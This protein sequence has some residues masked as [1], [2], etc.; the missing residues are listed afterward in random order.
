VNTEHREAELKELNGKPVV[1]IIPQGG[2]SS[3]SVAGILQVVETEEHAVGFHVT[4]LGIAFMFFG[5]D[6]VSLEVSNHQEFAKT[7]R[8]R[9]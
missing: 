5:A 9:K 4:N 2:R 8:I 7:I 1:L 3:L 6:V